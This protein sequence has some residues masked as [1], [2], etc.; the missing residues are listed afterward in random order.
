MVGFINFVNFI[1]KFSQDFLDLYVL[2]IMIKVEIY[3]NFKKYFFGKKEDGK[4]L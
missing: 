1:I 4:V 2:I 3:L